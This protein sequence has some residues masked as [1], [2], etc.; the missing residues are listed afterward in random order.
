[1]LTP[2]YIVSY[3]AYRSRIRNCREYFARLWFNV[4]YI[5]LLYSTYYVIIILMVIF[6]GSRNYYLS[7]Y[8]YSLYSK[9]YLAF[10][11]SLLLLTIPSRKIAVFVFSWHMYCTCKTYE[12]LRISRCTLLTKETW[13]RGQL[14]EWSK[15]WPSYCSVLVK[16]KKFKRQTKINPYLYYD[17]ATWW[18]VLQQLRHKM[19]LALISAIT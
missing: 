2:Y 7:F 14:S 5:I 19:V 8:Y 16:V 13:G 11:S 10:T 3:F 1:M 12:I 17:A 6:A 9:K 4:Y 18:W 15:L